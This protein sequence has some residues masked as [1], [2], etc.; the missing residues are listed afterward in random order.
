LDEALCP[1]TKAIWPADKLWQHP[2]PTA[3]AW[4][5]PNS[6]CAVLLTPCAWRQHKGNAAHRVRPYFS[7]R[8]DPH[9][10]GCDGKVRRVQTVGTSPS[11]TAMPTPL[12]L[13]SRIH[14]KDTK[15]LAARRGQGAAASR[16]ATVGP[17]SVSSRSPHHH[18]LFGTI[19]RACAAFEAISP[20]T[21][22]STLAV[23]DCDGT[24]Y[25]QIFRRLDTAYARRGRDMRKI[26]YAE[27]IRAIGLVAIPGRIRLEIPGRWAK[28]TTGVSRWTDTV[29]VVIDTRAWPAGLHTRLSNRIGVELVKSA[30]MPGLRAYIFFQ[31]APR[32][33][34]PL[35][36]VVTDFR[37]V[38]VLSTPKR[39]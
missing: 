26:F 15:Q 20:N 3:V 13:P 6:L 9:I 24:T 37:R 16:V 21:Q 39:L 29:R 32:S 19:S 1:T 7:A 18:R 17:A 36:F 28:D 14:F 12:S 8:H 23:D 22:E 4:E 34:D 5:C 30:S 31:G 27:I 33:A 35:E 10:I 11:G 25:A 2:T 38:A